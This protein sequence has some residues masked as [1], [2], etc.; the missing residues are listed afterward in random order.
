[1]EQRFLA[2]DFDRLFQYFKFQPSSVIFRSSSLERAYESCEAFRDRWMKHNRLSNSSSIQVN[3]ELLL[4][5]NSC[6]E[7][8]EKVLK[9]SS[10]TSFLNEFAS[11][12]FVEKIG[13]SIKEKL[14]LNKDFTISSTLIENLWTVN[15]I[16]NA[17]GFTSE[18]SSIFDDSD[19]SVMEFLQ[20]MEFFWQRSYGDR[21]CIKVACNLLKDIAQNVMFSFHSNSARFDFSHAEVLVPILANFGIGEMDEVLTTDSFL[22]QLEEREFRTSKITP[23]AANVAFPIFKC[24]HQYFV[25]MLLNGE[26]VHIKKC[27]RPCPLENFSE[28]Y[29]KKWL[30]C[31]FEEICFNFKF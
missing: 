28:I 20:D 15:A 29:L 3:D 16:E 21:L 8:D 25:D 17:A 9:N 4:F 27:P 5:F 26:P 22:W 1:M 7:F 6:L 23:F 31:D 24:H 13:E 30:N 19:L 10:V 12:I 11:S 18:L 14:H 2:E